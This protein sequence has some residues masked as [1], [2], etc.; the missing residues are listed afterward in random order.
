MKRDL[1]YLVVF[2]FILT[3]CAPSTFIVSNGIRSNYFGSESKGAYRMLCSSG[4]LKKVLRRAELPEEIKEDIYEY[5]CTEH[6]SNKK[7]ISLYTFLTP[8]E[9]KSLKRAFVRHGYTVNSVP[10]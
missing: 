6:R 10:C 4:D 8:E 7:M 9:K 2:S 1:L 3:G 5:A